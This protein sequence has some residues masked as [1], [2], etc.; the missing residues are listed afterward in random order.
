MQYQQSRH[1]RFF[2]RGIA[3]TLA[4]IRETCLVFR[5]DE[6][7]GMSIRRR[8]GRPSSLKIVRIACIFARFARN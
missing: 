1:G 4:L 3:R 7:A 8:T 6:T 2:F 5:A